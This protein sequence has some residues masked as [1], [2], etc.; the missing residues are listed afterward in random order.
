VN[1]FGNLIVVRHIMNYTAR[2][3]KKIKF[4]KRILHA[5]RK[6]HYKA[7]LSV[8]KLNFL[9]VQCTEYTEYRLSGDYM[10]VTCDNKKAYCKQRR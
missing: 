2:F 7:V 5:W 10:T 6:L 9:R 4:V 1:H 8:S 3:K